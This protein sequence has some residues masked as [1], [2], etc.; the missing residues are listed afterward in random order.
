[1][2]TK[3]EEFV[4]RNRRRNKQLYADDAIAGYDYVICPVSN[5]RKTMIEAKYIT[6]TLGMTTEE[7]DLLYPDIQKIATARLDKIKQGLHQIDENTGLTKYQ[8]SQSKAKESLQSIGDDGLSGYARKGKKTRQT[9]M[10]NVDEFGRNGYTR[11]AHNRLTTILPNG[12]TV[13]QNAHLKQKETLITNNI[14][15]TGGASK[16]SK[17]KLKPILDFLI[18]NNIEFYFDETEYGIKDTD[19]QRY[20]FY[21]LTILKYNITIEYQSN[22]WHSNPTWDDIKWNNWCPPRGKKKT[23]LESL[24][25]DYNKARSLYKFRNIVTYYVWEDTADNDVRDMICLLQTMNMKY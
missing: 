21:D 25:Y 13:E 10:N 22:A 7:Y 15:G 2:K 11:Q 4:K 23:A 16:I 19:T 1:M 17:K 14:G 8:L 18:E 12:L 24:D 5:A 20:Y 3:L 6:A 9:H